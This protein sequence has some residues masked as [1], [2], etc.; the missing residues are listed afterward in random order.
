MLLGLGFTD[1]T[2]SCK[3]CV[4]G[5]DRGRLN[6]VY[7][8]GATRRVESAPEQRSAAPNCWSGTAVECW[9]GASGWEEL[10]LGM[11]CR[12]HWDQ[13]KPPTG[14][15]VT[16]GEW[17]PR[18]SERGTKKGTRVNGHRRTWESGPYPLIRMI[19]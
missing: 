7:E 2:L 10:A 5:G 6:V 4:H 13:G 16:T 1:T 15:M 12:G 8:S 11:T 9:S 18:V 14:T 3:Q 17:R 19:M